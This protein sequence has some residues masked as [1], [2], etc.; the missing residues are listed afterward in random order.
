[1]R[2][3]GASSV[4]SSRKHAAAPTGAAV[5]QQARQAG[6][7][8]HNGTGSSSNSHLQEQIE[9]QP[10]TTTEAVSQSK[11]GTAQEELDQL[12]L[13]PDVH[14]VDS[15]EDAQRVAQL[16]L[17]KPHGRVLAVD[18]EVSDIDVT[19]E[20]PCGHGRVICFS[21]YGGPDIHFGAEPPTKGAPRQD[22]LW[23]DTMLGNDEEEVT[24]VFEAFRPVLEDP[25]ILKVWHNYSF[26]RHVLRNHGIE[27]RGF[28]GDT[29][30]M[31]RLWDSSRQGK[32]Y[33]LESLTGDKDLMED[34]IKD[35]RHKTG[36]KSLFGRKNQKK[37]G[38]DGKLT[39]LDPVE[40]LQ[41]CPERRC[42]WISYSAY[43]AKAT[44]Q[45]SQALQ[46]KLKIMKCEMDPALQP[47]EMGRCRNM[48]EMYKDF[49]RP[50]GELLTDMEKEGMMVN[51]EHL[52][53]AQKRANIDQE[54]ASELFKRWASSKVPDAQHMNVGSG[55]QL[56]QLLYAGVANSKSKQPAHKAAAK[57]E[58]AAADDR[59]ELERV[60]KVPNVISYVEPDS[61]T[62]KPKKNMDIRLYG[63][64]GQGQPVGV[65]PEVFT[66]SGWPAVSTPVL[67][68]LAGKPGAAL[69]ALK[70][71]YGVDLHVAE[72]IDAIDDIDVDAESADVVTSSADEAPVEGDGRSPGK[73]QAAASK[74]DGKVPAAGKGAAAQSAAQQPL[75]G[76][77]EP[78]T[79]SFKQDEQEAKAKGYGKFYAAFGGQKEGLEACA[80]IDAICEVGAIDTLLSNFIIPLQGDQISTADGRVHCSLN[81]N[82]ETGRLSARRPNLQNQPALEKDRYKVRQ[83]FTA[84][85]S[86][87]NT[88]IVADYG[89]LELRLLAHMAG[90]QSM[91]LAFQLGGDFHSRT[92]LGMYDHIKKAVGAGDCLLEWDGVGKPPVPLL[93]E[94]FASER[95]KAKVLNF[96]IAYGKTAFGLSKDWNV[97]LKEAE[98]TVDRWYSDR[99]EVLEWQVQQR[100]EAERLGRVRTMLG[101]ERCLPDAQKTA[102]EHS[103]ARGHAL[104]AAINTPIQGSAADVATVAMLRI[105]RHQRLRDLGWTML[106]QV[107]DEVILEGPKATAAEAQQ[108]VIKCM[109][110]PFQED[111]NP[112][113]VDLVVDSK[114]ADTWYEAK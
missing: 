7:A 109:Q 88:L 46:A 31:A 28:H 33:S 48:W 8:S 96:S 37:D 26:D 106:L 57:G 102:S 29:M 60:F 42:K 98:D 24:A 67:R 87:G 35:L 27:C 111:F 12:A 58:A 20:S 2:Q 61:K 18:T 36:M 84:D 82:T 66:P 80:A 113:H 64:W 85:V 72:P 55:T 83:A 6:K 86:K 52:A 110:Y 1:M 44:W 78:S 69:K 47:L 56:R 45:L 43:D 10:Y 114:I 23:V 74:R 90:C 30:H 53:E 16:L 39:V 77:E 32:G 73:G 22:Q 68:S 63:L 100:N 95:R 79:Q 94:K 70:E 97:S 103:R 11:P 38:T 40:V 17:T 108:L 91:I 9:T 54:A 62:K 14:V 51:R 101:R 76:V 25:D 15:A 81:L 71:K 107:H 75:E 99:H 4:G 112:L 50:F 19:K 3:P 21:I 93:K 34:Y 104:R 105:S 5:V 65:Q 59:L 49:W 92:A 41:L 89:Q 13:P